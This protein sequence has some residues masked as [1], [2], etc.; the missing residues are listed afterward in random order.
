MFGIESQEELLFNDL[1]YLVLKRI[2]IFTFRIFDIK[3]NEYPIILFFNN[4]LKLTDYKPNYHQ[5]RL[6]KHIKSVFNIN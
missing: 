4:I 2:A 3:T 6:Q 1:F 5:N